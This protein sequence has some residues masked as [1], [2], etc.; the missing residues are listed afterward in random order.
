MAITATI[1]VKNQDLLTSLKAFCVNL[2]EQETISAIL[3]PQRLPMKS[4]VMPTLVTDVAHLDGVDPLSPAFPMNGA[5]VL[6][7]LTRRPSGGRI[8]AV[9]R[10]CEIRAFVELVK[11]KQARTEDVVLIG[12]DCLGAYRNTDY[13][14]LAGDDAEGTTRR[15]YEAVLSGKG[16]AL[17]GADLTPACQA[18]EASIPT[19][20]DI[21]LGL[22]GVDTGSHVLVQGQTPAGDELLQQMG[23][24]AGEVPGKREAALTQLRESRE[25]HRDQMFAATAAATDS[26]EKL[27]IYLANC[28]NCYNCRVACPVCYCKECVFVTDVFN[29]DPAQYLRW[30]K[31]KGAVKM[32]TDTVFYHLTRLTHISTACV[33]CGQCSNACPNDIPVMELFR[34]VAHRTQK[35]F[36]YEAGRSV[37]EEPPLSVFKEDEFQEVVGL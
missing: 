30:A 7:K 16:A 24:S 29:H 12:L 26:V 9:L 33:G 19:G 1:D 10:P 27:N 4:M 15:F 2:L 20:A 3:V 25:A 36:D 37:A 34:L 18:C 35:A 8:A 32:P 17:E 14:R 5:K 21:A 13:F 22:W 23:L 28:I 11:L 31:H 6:A